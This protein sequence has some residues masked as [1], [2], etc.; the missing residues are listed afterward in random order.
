[1]T[2]KSAGKPFLRV[3]LHRG[4]IG[5]PR[6]VRDSARAIGL[7]KRHQTVYLRPTPIAIGNLLKIKELVKVSL[8]AARPAPRSGPMHPK[9]YA[10]LHSLLP[11]TTQP[12]HLLRK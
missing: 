10:V 6:D 2:A 5:L 1:M 7:T 9:G 3:L 8:A 11:P 12:F 4:F